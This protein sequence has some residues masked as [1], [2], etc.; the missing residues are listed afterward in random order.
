MTLLIAF[1]RDVVLVSDGRQSAAT[2]N[3]T[4]RDSSY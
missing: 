4:L 1:M 3:M 2:L